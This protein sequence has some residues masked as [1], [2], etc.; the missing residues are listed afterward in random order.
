MKKKNTM[1]QIYTKRG[2]E[3][4]K[5]RSRYTLKTNEEEKHKDTDIH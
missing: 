3:E 1:I 5:Q 4:E 2:N